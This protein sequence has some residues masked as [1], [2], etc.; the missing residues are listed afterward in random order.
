MSF[1]FCL[2]YFSL[3]NKNDKNTYWGICSPGTSYLDRRTEGGVINRDPKMMQIK[4][5][6]CKK[7]LP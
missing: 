2:F 5:H 3:K 4:A 7:A 6:V 1:Y